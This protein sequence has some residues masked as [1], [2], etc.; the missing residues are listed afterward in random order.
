MIW[1]GERQENIKECRYLRV[2]VFPFG[3]EIL[4]RL[5]WVKASLV[6]SVS[7]GKSIYQQQL[8]TRIVYPK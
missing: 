5:S 3:F 7:Y 2:R 8:P 1:G 6:G 4:L